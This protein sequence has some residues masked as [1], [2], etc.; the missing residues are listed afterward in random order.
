[1]AARHG[2]AVTFPMLDRTVVD[3]MLSLP[4]HHFVHDGYSRQ[5]FRTAMEGIL[6]DEVRLAQVKVGL[7]DERFMGYAELK[8]KLLLSLDLLR[9]SVDGQSTIFDLDAIGAGLRLLPD[10]AR[11]NDISQLGRAALDRDTPPWLP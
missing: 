2:L 5:P 10:A 11:L 1:M 8:E 6:P 4:L 7:F 9:A 3:F